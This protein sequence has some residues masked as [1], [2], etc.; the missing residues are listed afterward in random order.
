MRKLMLV[1]FLAG[2]MSYGVAGIT[3][4]PK[5]VGVEQSVKVSDLETRG[6]LA[7]AHREFVMAAGYYRSALRLDPRNSS[8]YNKL[9][10][11]ELRDGDLHAAKAEFAR[12]AKLNPKDARALNNLGAVACLQKKYKPATKYL[13]E[14]LALDETDATLHVNLGEAWMGLGKIDRAM[15]EYSRALEL[16]GDIFSSMA[17]EGVTA[18]L[19]TPEQQA[20]VSYLIAKAYAKRGNL[21]GAL[22][23]LRRAKENRYPEMANVYQDTEFAG[24]WQD[25]RLTKL[26]PR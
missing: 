13:K 23:Y 26:V 14:A 25:P 19:R 20:R 10:I 8:L 16:D 6:D 18:Q 7:R 11:V 4:L 15:T 12:A 1:G 22:E 24:L 17:S 3:D 2:S 9:G 21:D 5:A